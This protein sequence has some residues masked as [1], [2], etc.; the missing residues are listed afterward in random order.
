MNRTNA[1]FATVSALLSAA[2][3]V[4]LSPTLASAHT[5][6]GIYVV[7]IEGTANG[8][9]TRTWSDGEVQSYIGVQKAIKACWD[10]GGGTNT[11]RC[12]GQAD[13][14]YPWLADWK[15]SLEKAK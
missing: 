13:V 10:L 3:V 5:E 9:F 8:G 6:G 11:F 1:A 4:G 2:V 15:R 14:T 7:S 12:L